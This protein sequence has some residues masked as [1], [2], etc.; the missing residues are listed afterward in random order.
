MFQKLLA[1]AGLTA[2]LAT[3]NGAPLYA[4]EMV[5]QSQRS[6]PIKAVVELFTSQGCSSCP[7]ADTL[8][9]TYT[10]AGDVLALS[11]P[12]DYWDYLGWKD[13]LANPK[14]SERQRAY[15]RTLGSGSVY[16]PQ[17]V[18]NGVAHVV[19]S[20][21][22]E[23]DSTIEAGA[24][25]FTD[26]Q[27]PVRFWRHESIF[28]IDL[29]AAPEGLPAQQST[30]WFA[31]IQKNAHVTIKRGENAGKTLSYANVVRELVPVGVWDGTPKSLQVASASVMQ[32]EG[33]EQVIIVQ[34]STSGEIV[35]AAYMSH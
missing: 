28:Y 23:I 30:V 20:N 22:A 16:T 26:H 14:N 4:G 13:T 17:V 27:I 7:P 15:A 25:R 32:P 19:G 2:V 34:N 33:E 24:K 29:G 8:F 1:F 10:E 12:V 5:P 31:V 21:K 35:G 11:L 3:A 6:Q 9:R 18:I